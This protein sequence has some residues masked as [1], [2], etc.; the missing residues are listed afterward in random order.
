MATEASAYAALQGLA[1]RLEAFSLDLPKNGADGRKDSDDNECL[2]I[3]EAERLVSRGRLRGF[4]K[5]DFIRGGPRAWYDFAFRLSDAGRSFFAPVNVKIS[6]FKGA[7]NI[8]AKLGIYYALTGLHPTCAPG[9]SWPDFFT[10]LEDH[11]GAG[12]DADYYFLVVE[13]SEESAGRIFTQSLR[14]LRRIVPNGN[15]VPFQCNWAQN[16]DPHPYRNLRDAERFLVFD[17]LHTSLE[18]RAQAYRASERY[19]RVRGVANE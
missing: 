6:S 15:N 4:G 9:V 2:V 8:S 1:T 10:L 14:R 7:D 5:I 18:M 19:I 11:I 12:P 3:D 13:K 17:G 16:L